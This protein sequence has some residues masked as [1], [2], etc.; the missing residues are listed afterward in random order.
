MDDSEDATTRAAARMLARR[1]H[2]RAELARKLAR[3]AG[4]RAAAA[5]VE[6]IASAGLLDDGRFAASLAAR[7]LESGWGPARIEHDLVA[8]GVPADVVREALANLDPEDVRRS[9]F[10]AA[11]GAAGPAAARRLAARGFGEEE[12][13]AV[14][15][16]PDD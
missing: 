8:A 6:R 14:S 1:D 4:D 10:T 16:N 5:A 11:R 12:I 2:G 7:R 3:T 13:E 15:A 9:A